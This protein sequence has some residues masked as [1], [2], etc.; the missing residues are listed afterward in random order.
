MRVTKIVFSP[1]GGTQK[2]ADIV[3]AKLGSDIQSIDLA[4]AK[5][6]YSENRFN[7]DDVV[8]IAMPSFG[9]RAPETAVKRFLQI[10]G[11]GATAIVIA[12]YGNRAQE[13]TLVEMEDA[14]KQSGFKV[15]AGIATIAEHSILRQYASGRPNDED[16]SQLENFA[17]RIL[18]KIDSNADND[19]KIIGNRPYKKAGGAGMVP[20]AT[21]TCTKCGVCAKACPVGAI[22][23]KFA[24]DGKKCISC[25]RC[26]SVCPSKAR[27]LNGA[28]VSAAGLALKKA[29][30]VHKDNELF[31]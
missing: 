3:A 18:E 31:I 28:M 9:G 6:N 24:A 7:A 11:N 4:C 21:K 20:K 19:P 23:E 16:K 17:A 12:V 15:V 10:K 25:M 14:A 27:K 13:D 29:C 30:S 26:I 8:V 1:T 22:D 5:D 2:V